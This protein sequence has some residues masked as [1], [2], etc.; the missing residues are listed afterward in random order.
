MPD[1]RDCPLYYIETSGGKIEGN[2]GMAANGC[3][4]FGKKEKVFKWETP[5]DLWKLQ[6][7]DNIIRFEKM[8]QVQSGDQSKG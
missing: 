4:Y 6:S 2:C 8:D 3:S 7:W 1:M 5:E